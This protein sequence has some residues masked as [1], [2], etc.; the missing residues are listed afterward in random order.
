MVFQHEVRMFPP[1]TNPQQLTGFM[2]MVSEQGWEIVSVSMGPPGFLVTG[3]RPAGPASADGQ[4]E[5]Q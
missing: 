1:N 3:R 4:W 5:G 2:N